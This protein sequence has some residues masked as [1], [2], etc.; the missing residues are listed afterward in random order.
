MPPSFDHLLGIRLQLFGLDSIDR[1]GRRECWWH[2]IAA[3]EGIPM[4]DLRFGVAQL[5]RE[6]EQIYVQFGNFEAY[7][8]YMRYLV[9]TCGVCARPSILRVLRH[10]VPWNGQ[11]QGD[12][13]AL[14]SK[15]FKIATSM[16]H[17]SQ[18]ARLMPSYCGLEH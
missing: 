14:E 13:S 7:G 12:L 15:N 8:G 11:H 18:P 1:G 10:V 16:R 5:M 9:A 4:K 3:A 17:P 2:C 6:N